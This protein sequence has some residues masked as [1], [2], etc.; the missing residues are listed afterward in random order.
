MKVIIVRG[1]PGSGKSTWINNNYPRASICSADHFFIDKNDNYNF[2]RN[3]IGEAHKECMAT[4]LTYVMT[5]FFDK[6]RV[7]RSPIIVDNTNI[8]IHEVTPYLRVAEAFGY[9][10]EVVRIGSDPDTAYKRNTHG[11]PLET[12]KRMHKSMKPLPSWM[13]KETIV[14]NK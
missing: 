1:I 5:E 7:L 6:G 14:I 9:E 8:S 13:G 2:D 10:V 4:F 12:I 3:K 11:V